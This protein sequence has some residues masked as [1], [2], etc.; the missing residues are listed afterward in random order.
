[1]RWIQEAFYVSHM[2]T[3]IAALIDHRILLSWPRHARG[4]VKAHMINALF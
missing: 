2:L 3:Q 1:V 4:R